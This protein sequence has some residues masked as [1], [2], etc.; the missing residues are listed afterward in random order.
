MVSIRPALISEF[1]ALPSVP[2]YR[3]MAIMKQKS[4]NYVG[5]LG[6]V[7]RGL[8]MYAEQCLREDAVD[9][10]RKRSD[11]LRAKLSTS[12]LEHQNRQDATR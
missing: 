6:W 9:D 1:G 2:M 5:A 8:A 10:L 3:Q 11:K 12:T 4:R 7:D